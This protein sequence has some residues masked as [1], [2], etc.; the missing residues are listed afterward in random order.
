MHVGNARV[1]QQQSYRKNNDGKDGND[2]NNLITPPMTKRSTTLPSD[3][4]IVVGSGTVQS[5]SFVAI[6]NVECL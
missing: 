1:S 6:C 2:G 5:L 4:S 3:I